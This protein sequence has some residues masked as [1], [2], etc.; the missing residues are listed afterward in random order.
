M[1]TLQPSQVTPQTTTVVSF[2]KDKVTYNAVPINQPVVDGKRKSV[3][4]QHQ[5]TLDVFAGI[6]APMTI[7]NFKNVDKVVNNKGKSKEVVKLLEKPL[8][9]TSY[10]PLEAIISSPDEALAW[11]TNDEILGKPA[12]PKM[13]A[14]PNAMVIED[15]DPYNFDKS[16]SDED[17]MPPRPVEAYMG[18]WGDGLDNKIAEAARFDS[19]FINEGQVPSTVISNIDSHTKQSAFLAGTIMEEDLHKLT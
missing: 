17:G 5:R 8:A 4:A 11:C 7:Q 13:V 15:E 1:I 9:S 14:D 12:S 18:G 2:G 16:D 19:G 10:A 6:N 3:Y